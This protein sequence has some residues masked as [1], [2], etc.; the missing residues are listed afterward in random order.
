MRFHK[1]IFHDVCHVV[2]LG[3][4]DSVLVEIFSRSAVENS[5][6]VSSAIIAMSLDMSLTRPL[7]VSHSGFAKILK[8]RQGHETSPL[9][10]IAKSDVHPTIGRRKHV[11]GREE[12]VG[13]APAVH[14]D[15]KMSGA[16]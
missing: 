9:H 10:I 11:H 2:D 12:L 5:S 13:I 4:G 7:L 6:L 8:T 15:P 3:S 16:W 1:R 14:G